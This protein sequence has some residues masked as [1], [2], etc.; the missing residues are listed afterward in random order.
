M[1][2]TVYIHIAGKNYP[3]RM[4]L[5]AAKAITGKFGSM[6]KMADAMTDKQASEGKVIDTALWMLETLIRQ[7]CA[8]K[9]LFEKDLP[10]PEDAPVENGKYIPLSAE[11]L[12]TGIGMEGIKEAM[13]KIMETMGKGGAREIKIKERKEDKKNGETT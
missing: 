5:G 2:R 12:E 3:M 1:D 11:E 10:I 9:N 7:G 4:S 8:Y 6:E 13:D